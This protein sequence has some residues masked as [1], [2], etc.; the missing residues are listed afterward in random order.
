LADQHQHQRTCHGGLVAD[1]FPDRAPRQ[2]QRN[3]RREIEADQESDIG[4]AGIEFGAEQRRDRSDALKLETP[5]S[6]AP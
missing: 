6:A 1:P 2:R 4:K 5:W 3:A